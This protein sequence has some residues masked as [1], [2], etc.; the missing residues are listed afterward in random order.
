MNLVDLIA[1][2]FVSWMVIIVVFVRELYMRLC[3][4]GRAVLSDEAF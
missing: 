2:S 1:V 3:K 4:F